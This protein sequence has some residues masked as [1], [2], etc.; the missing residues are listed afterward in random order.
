MLIVSLMMQCHV[1]VLLVLVVLLSMALILT[2]PETDAE[3][4]FY[5]N[6]SSTANGTDGRWT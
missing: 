2:C 3:H 4:D 1:V 5:P 6:D